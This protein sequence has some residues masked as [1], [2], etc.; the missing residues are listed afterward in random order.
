MIEWDINKVLRLLDTPQ[1]SEE[2]LNWLDEVL[3]I[4]IEAYSDPELFLGPVDRSSLLHT[5]IVLETKISINR[6]AKKN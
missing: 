3:N 1:L 5:I 2:D 4:Q 6:V